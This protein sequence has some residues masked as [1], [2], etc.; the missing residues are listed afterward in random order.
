M[1]GSVTGWGGPSLRGKGGPPTDRARGH[2]QL[3]VRPAWG[4]WG[5]QGRGLVS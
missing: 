1:D 5:V 3:A 4:G 2:A